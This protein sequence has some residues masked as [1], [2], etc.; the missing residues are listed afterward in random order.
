[1]PF[2][3][4]NMGININT[5]NDEYWPSLSADEQTL[6]FTRLL[7][8]NNNNPDLVRNRQE[9]LYYSIFE[10]GKMDSCKTSRS[11]YKYSGNEGAQ[12]I[13]ADGKFM[14]F[15]GCNREDGYGSCDLYF[16][17]RE[18]DTWSNPRNIGKPINTQY[19]ETQ[20][21]LSADGKTLYFASN[22]P[23]GK[24]GL[25]IWKSSINSN[26]IW[27]EPV[28]LGDSINTPYDEQSP[29]IHTDNNTLYFSSNGWPGLGNFDLFVSHKKDENDWTTP[30]NLGY[31]INTHFSE[32]G[33]IVNA[34][35]N[36]AYY[37][38]N[39]EGEGGRDLFSFELYKEARP[40]VV[41]Y[42]KGSVYDAE[43]K[44]PLRARFELIDLNRIIP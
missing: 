23:S 27:S 42:M 9:D 44:L 25:D 39:R 4:I 43:S 29:F 40:D 5:E 17:K 18:G 35:G 15:T 13:S 24:G 20:P 34:K 3:P 12:T 30:K 33:L 41:S 38:S 7:P 37:S 14:V 11:S 16:S 28:N 10:N 32:E 21:S 2:N 1:M 26:G 31:P 6:V 19:K 8:I 36:M 22:R